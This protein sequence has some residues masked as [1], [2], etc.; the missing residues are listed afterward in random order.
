MGFEKSADF[1]NGVYVD[2]VEVRNNDL[3]NVV[4]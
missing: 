4:Y 1:G 2:Q 3:N